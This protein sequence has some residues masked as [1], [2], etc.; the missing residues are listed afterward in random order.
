MPLL[1]GILL[2]VGAYFIAKEL[3]EKA[4]EKKQRP[5]QL[6]PVPTNIM[7][8][9]DWGGPQYASQS[10]G[11]PWFRRAT[12]PRTSG[13]AAYKMAEARTGNCCGGCSS[14]MGCDGC[15]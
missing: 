3:A 9:D 11:W 15:G 5:Q 12:T 13:R 8:P 7:Y 14:G 2:G 4:E 1:L 6:P 10:P